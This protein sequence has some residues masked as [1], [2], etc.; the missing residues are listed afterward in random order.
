MS[1]TAAPKPSEPE[2]QLI[3]TG[4]IESAPGK[5]EIKSNSEWTITALKVYR[6]DFTKVQSLPELLEILNALDMR[7]Y[8]GSRQHAELVEYLVEV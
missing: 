5:F 8:E 4:P 1:E 7:V 6:L 3:L 2:N